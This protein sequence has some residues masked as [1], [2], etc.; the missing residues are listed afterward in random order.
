MRRWWPPLIPPDDGPLVVTSPF[1]P[2][3][4]PVTGEESMHTGVD[5]R[6]P[7][8]TPIYP[9]GDGYVARIFDDEINGHGVLI[10]HGTHRL[11]DGTWSPHYWSAYVHMRDRPLVEVGDAVYPADWRRL[12]GEITP[13][14]TVLGYVGSTGRSTGP[15]LH[16]EVREGSARVDPLPVVD[17]ARFFELHGGDPVQIPP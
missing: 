14:A 10:N 5:L 6:A 11:A 2:R 7:E 12:A 15:H 3:V 9:I 1:G 4:H 17:W 8:G 13:V 16:L